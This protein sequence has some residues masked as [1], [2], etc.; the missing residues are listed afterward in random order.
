MKSTWL[1]AAIAVLA[2]C[3]GTKPV[4]K[5]PEAG[6]TTTAAAPVGSQPAA[7]TRSP[8]QPPLPS[9][10]AVAFEQ[11]LAL[12]PQAEGWTRSE[13]RGEQVGMG[14][15]M[16]R[17]RAQ[18]DKGESSIDLEITDSSFNQLVLSPMAMFLTAGYSERST[19]GY[20]RSAAV[21][22]HPG[23]EKW[24]D[25]S[26]RGEVTVVV[27]NRFIVQAS[28]SDVDDVETVRALVQAVDLGRLAGLR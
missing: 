15:T 7:Q 11:L 16:S 8:S 21:S 2:A 4:E 3:G 26:K 12:L 10:T 22:G 28:G 1:I 9:A 20:A 14:I 5:P 25:A 27:G 18:Y 23:F 17:A 24:I 6:A 13:P 19:N